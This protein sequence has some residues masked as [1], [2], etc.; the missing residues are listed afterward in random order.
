MSN[1]DEAEIGARFKMGQAMRRMRLCLVTPA[2]PPMVG[3]ISRT[4]HDLAQGLADRGHEVVVLVACARLPHGGYTEA[5]RESLTVHWLVDSTS[6]LRLL[7]WLPGGGADLWRSVRVR[8]ALALL[9]EAQGRFDAVEF[10]SWRALGAVHSLRKVAPQVLRATTGI[11]QVS[12]ERSSWLNRVFD[13]VGRLVLDGAERLCLVN[14]DVVVAPTTS[15]LA[16]LPRRVR[17]TTTI[18]PFGVVLPTGC[19]RRSGTT[20]LFVGRLS[21]RKGFDLFAQAAHK[22]LTEMPSAR[23]VVVGHDQMDAEGSAWERYGAQLKRDFEERVNWRVELSDEELNELYW[24]GDVCAMASRY[25]SFGLVIVE[26][27]LHGMPVV[28][29]DTDFAREV[30]GD[31]AILVPRWDVAAY[32]NALRETL[33]ATAAGRIDGEMIREVTERRF[34]MR[35]FIDHT[36]AVYANAAR[37]HATDR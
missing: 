31:L 12:E 11:A 24:S 28:A 21:G 20:V 33:E 9:Q 37:Q 15:H 10:A 7:T 36:E 13:R 2:Y 6:P 29:W 1:R 5:A 32:A 34:G 25:E 27:N 26:A 4:T 3:G 17:S 19:P 18:M 23:V 8:R 14:S 16:H 22:L 35:R 30:A